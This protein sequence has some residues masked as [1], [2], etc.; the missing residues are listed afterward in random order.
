MFGCGN[1]AQRGAL[2]SHGRLTPG[3]WKGKGFGKEEAPFEILGPHTGVWVGVITGRVLGGP[4]LA[5]T[6]RSVV[7][8]C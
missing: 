8:V 1:G 2:D 3:R 6:V 5:G 7:S 4:L